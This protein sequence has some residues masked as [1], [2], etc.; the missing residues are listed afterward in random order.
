M[1]SIIAGGFFLLKFVRRMVGKKKAVASHDET[2][3]WFG[4]QDPGGGGGGA[5]VWAAG[6]ADRQ[7]YFGRKKKNATHWAVYGIQY[8]A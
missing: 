4:M 6:L 1:E 2:I 5:A 3:R 7:R 8:E